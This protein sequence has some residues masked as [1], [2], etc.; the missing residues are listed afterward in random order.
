L[1]RNLKRS[2]SRSASCVPVFSRDDSF[3]VESKIGAQLP[4][5][6]CELAG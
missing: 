6:G 1:T 3:G 4:S 5:A 2:A